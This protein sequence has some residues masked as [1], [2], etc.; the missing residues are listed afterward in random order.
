MMVDMNP[1]IR[2]TEN[3]FK[4]E[5]SGP[6]CSL[7]TLTTSNKPKAVITKLKRLNMGLVLRLNI[8]NVKK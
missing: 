7:Y 2:L 4:K 6:F 5:K 1:V 8:D 3:A